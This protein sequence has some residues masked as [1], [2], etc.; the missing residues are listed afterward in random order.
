MQGVFLGHRISVRSISPCNR[1]RFSSP[2]IS[3][4]RGA[5]VTMSQAGHLALV[6]GGTG[7]VAGE[8]VKQLL[9]KGYQVRTTV[10]PGTDVSRLQPLKL[11]AQALPGATS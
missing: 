10:R 3:R 2:L 9:E 4:A 8:L 1:L 7:F 11:L 6:T 5:W